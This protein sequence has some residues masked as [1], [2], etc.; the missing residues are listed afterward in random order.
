M[1]K[2]LI[3]IIL[4]LLFTGCAKEK[5]L[6]APVDISDPLV[7]SEEPVEGLF[8]FDAGY[9]GD[10]EIYYDYYANLSFP[11]PK[12]WEVSIYS[13]NL[14]YFNSENTQITVSHNPMVSKLE[15]YKDFAD[16]FKEIWLNEPLYIRDGKWFR[17]ERQKKDA[18]TVISQDP[19]LIVETYDN[20]KL[21]ND[22]AEYVSGE[23]KE[24]RYY[25]YNDGF[26]TMI[27]MITDN[28]DNFVILDHLIVNLSTA[29]PIE[30]KS[31]KSI[32]GIAF[33]DS[34]QEIPID[35]AEFHGKAY[36][37]IDSDAYAGCFIEV[38]DREISLSDN[39]LDQLLSN[40]FQQSYNNHYINND[41][42]IFRDEGISITA[43]IS[44]ESLNWYTR[45]GNTYCLEV[46]PGESR[47][48]IV[49]YP[50]VKRDLMEKL[51]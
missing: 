40:A 9:S 21:S 18:M 10:C 13:P 31:T 25:L 19:R 43:T 26:N 38:F 33:P 22:M 3:M 37:P 24:K 44:T 46:Y 30:Y 23:Y 27:S 6:I 48:I 20:I 42:L 12:G 16:S 32:E 28:E 15:N 4:V 5:G 17:R 49:G 8:D 1:K 35:Y 39:S 34:F 7:I 29:G 14:I 36:L 51:K 41:E 50:I 45:T 11:Y 47:T 2:T